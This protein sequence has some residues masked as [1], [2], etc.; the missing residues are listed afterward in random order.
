MVRIILKF[1]IL[2]ITVSIISFVSWLILNQGEA[3]ITSQDIEGTDDYK[4]LVNVLDG[5]W[6]K[7]IDLTTT[8]KNAGNQL[9]L[10]KDQTITIEY[11]DINND[12]K[13]EIVITGR[14]ITDSEIKYILTKKEGKWKI[15]N[16][17]DP[18]GGISP[19]FDSQNI[20]LQDSDNDHIL[21]IISEYFVPY[22]NAPDQLWRT[23]YKLENND[24][25]QFIRRDKISLSVSESEDIANSFRGR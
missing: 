14:Y 6:Y 1:V 4:I 22:E 11:I 19:A 10:D 17:S 16:N 13:K 20:L 15:I 12:K 3:F 2:I 8:Y 9:A 18:F 7:K 21:E 5:W 24:F 23:H 25:Y